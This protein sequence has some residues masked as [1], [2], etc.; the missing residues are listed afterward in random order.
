MTNLLGSFNTVD[1]DSFLRECY[2]ELIVQVIGV[3]HF[4]YS[5]FVATLNMGFDEP[6]AEVT[7]QPNK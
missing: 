1:D 4:S 7:R 6:V 5:D 3:E 2:Q